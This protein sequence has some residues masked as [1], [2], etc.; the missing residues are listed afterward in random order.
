MRQWGS[1]ETICGFVH[2]L[3]IRKKG[4]LHVNSV[5]DW[6]GLATTTQRIPELAKCVLVDEK[7]RCEDEDDDVQFKQE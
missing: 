2:I 7:D 1:S 5:L 3:G 6:T 4:E